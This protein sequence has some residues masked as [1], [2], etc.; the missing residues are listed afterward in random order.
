MAQRN[1]VVVGASFAAIPVINGLKRKLPS[2]H[3]IIVV[4]PKSHF[5]FA[6]AFPAAA[7]ESGWEE[8][9]FIPYNNVLLPEQGLVIQAGVNEV[10]PNSVVLDRHIDA[11]QFANADSGTT[12][13]IPYDCLVYAAGAWHPSPTTMQ[14]F[15]TKSESIAELQTWQ[16]RIA[17]AKKPL[18]VGCGGSGA[19][20][21]AD[22]AEMYGAT[23]HLTVVHSREKYFDSFGPNVDAVVY[24]VLDKLGVVQ[25]R[26]E[27]VVFPKGGFPNDG[28]TFEV[29][30]STGRKIKADLVIPC[31][32]LVPNTSPLTI[33]SANLVNEQGFVNVL[34]TAQVTN[35]H[36]PNVF[37]VGDAGDFGPIKTA[38]EARK[39]AAVAVAN[40]L[41]M[42]REGPLHGELSHITR[43][44]PRINLI[45][46]KWTNVV[47]FTLWGCN[48]AIATR[49]GGFFK[50]LMGV[51][52]S[53]GAKKIWRAL[54]AK[55]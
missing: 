7:V 26:G 24:Q 29:E 23:K 10:H 4:D 43:S 19:E 30:T 48:I 53:P 55:M 16:D 47:V 38:K 31:T 52:G 44:A 28:S 39:Q 40:V 8:T 45:M 3:R 20:L 18:V 14:H 25:F 13:V 36:F 5:H 1:V 54:S 9:L 17:R 33:L 6:F 27:R 41:K 51:R 21:A 11:S 35:P 50:W 34:P 22:I 15:S 42:I 32:G 12:N 2:T 37:V 49:L 46:G